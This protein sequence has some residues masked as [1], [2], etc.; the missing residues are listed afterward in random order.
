LFPLSTNVERGIGGEVKFECNVLETED[1]HSNIFPISKGPSIV[2]KEVQKGSNQY[3]KNI[4]KKIMNVQHFSQEP[5]DSNVC[6]QTCTG[7]DMILNHPFKIF[8]SAFFPPIMPG[9]EIIQ[10]IVTYYG[11]LNSHK[12][13]EK[14]IYLENFGEEPQKEHI[15]QKSRSPHQ[16]ELKETLKLFI[17]SD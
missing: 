2:E 4:G 1:L 7:G 5:Q 3:A 8:N 13:G 14:I 16:T 12:A 15:H 9:P 11:K 17:L 6:K 10:H